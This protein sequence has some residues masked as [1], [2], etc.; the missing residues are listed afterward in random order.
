MCDASRKMFARSSRYRASHEPRPN[1]R[2]RHAPSWPWAVGGPAP[3]APCASASGSGTTGAEVLRRLEG[4]AGCLP[5]TTA[6]QLQVPTHWHLDFLVCR[7]ASLR[8]QKVP[9]LCPEQNRMGTA[10]KS[11]TFGDVFVDFT[12][13]EWQQLDSAQKN[14]YR[15]VTLENYS[16]L[17]SVGYLVPKPDEVLR[18]GRGEEARRAEGEPPTRSYPGL[19]QATVLMAASLHPPARFISLLRWGPTA[20]VTPGACSLSAGGGTEAT[21]GCRTQGFRDKRISAGT[22]PAAPPLCL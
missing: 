3:S 21:A 15:D 18:L 19:W 1:H 4:G 12:L 10:Q 14:L 2:P 8:P 22:I 20:T 7:R 16:H 17:V 5:E 13:E 11:L 6:H 9:A